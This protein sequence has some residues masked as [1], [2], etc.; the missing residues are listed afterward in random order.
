MH[1]RCTMERDSYMLN[2]QCRQIHACKMYNGERFLDV[3]CT[4]ER[5]LHVRST[6]ERDS[7]M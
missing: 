3:R 7:C 1:V 2:V 4:M 6:M 5:F